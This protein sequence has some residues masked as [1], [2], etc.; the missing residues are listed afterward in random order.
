MPID[1]ESK[2]RRLAQDAVE[3]ELYKEGILHRA[4]KLAIIHA[5]QYLFNLQRE[6]YLALAD[7]P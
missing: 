5:A 7:R 3:A 6:I 4:D 2:A 1:R